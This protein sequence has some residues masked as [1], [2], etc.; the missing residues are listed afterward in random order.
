MG[1]NSFGIGDSPQ[2]TEQGGPRAATPGAGRGSP[3]A[4]RHPRPL[5]PAGYSRSTG[6]VSP[7]GYVPSSTPQQSGYGGGAAG[8]N[9]YSGGTMAGLGVPGSPSFLNGSTANS[10]YASESPPV[11]P[12]P[13]TSP[14]VS[15]SAVC[16]PWH[17]R[18]AMCQPHGVPNCHGPALRCPKHQS[19]LSPR[20]CASYGTSPVAMCQP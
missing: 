3:A 20:S 8:I 9:G 4:P 11:F 17:V 12:A 16:Q 7:R 2:G 14:G 5:S 1:V 15:P 6:S 10:P 13:G 18:E 19:Q